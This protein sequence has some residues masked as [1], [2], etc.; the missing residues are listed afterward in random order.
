MT[1]LTTYAPTKE[2]LDTLLRYYEEEVI[3]EGYFQ[4]LAELAEKPDQYDKL[5]LL[6]VVEVHAYEITLPLLHKHN[7]KPRSKTVLFNEGRDSARSSKK[8]YDEHFE[9]MDRTF[10]GYVDDFL[11]LEAMA[12]PEDLPRLKIL[13]EHEVAAIK[14]L[15]LVSAGD[16]DY[17]APMD[18]YLAISI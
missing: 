16:P 4:T 5:H 3:G 8:T 9:E 1:N 17:A 12:P 2:Y 6:A 11:R 13:T 18:A 14:F 15:N 10:P 7:L